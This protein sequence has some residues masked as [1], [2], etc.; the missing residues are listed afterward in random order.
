MEYYTAKRKK[1]GAPTLHGSMNGTG[2]HYAK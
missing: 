1:E 2:E